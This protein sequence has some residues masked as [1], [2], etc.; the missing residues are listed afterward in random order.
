MIPA[1]V[2]TDI[3]APEAE[4]CDKIKEEKPK[5]RKVR[6]VIEF[7]SFKNL[8]EEGAKQLKKP[9]PYVPF[10]DSKPRASIMTAPTGLLTQETLTE[11]KPSE[12]KVAQEEEQK[13]VVEP[14]AKPVVE[15]TIRPAKRTS[16]I[17]QKSSILRPTASK[18]G[19]EEPAGEQT[20][21]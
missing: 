15:P 20:V 8:L 2:D 16:I 9:K 18:A 11:V 1:G 21:A 19:N 12:D 14:L 5:E 10:S 7:G 6:E 17:G 4:F 3:N 13:D